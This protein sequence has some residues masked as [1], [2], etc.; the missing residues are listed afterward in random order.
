MLALLHHPDQLAALRDNPTLAG[1]AV[2]E[3]LR[4]DPPFQ[5][6]RRVAVADLDIGGYYI[7][8]GRFLIVWLATANRDPARFRDPD[9]FDIHRTDTGHLA[10]GTGIHARLGGP[11]ARL[12]AEIAFAT[13][14]RR[15]VNPR[16]DI[17]PPPYR[18]D[19]YRSLRSLPTTAVITWPC[20]TQPPGTGSGC[21]A[22]CARCAG[23][24]PTPY[25]STS[26][27]TCWTSPAGPAAPAT[28]S[29]ENWSWC[30][31]GTLRNLATVDGPPGPRHLADAPLA[32]LLV[33]TGAATEFEPAARLPSWLGL[34][35]RT[36]RPFVQ[37]RRAGRCACRRPARRRC[38]R[39]GS[40]PAAPTRRP[41]G[42]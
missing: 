34:A 27:T 11:L 19:V 25:P 32:I 40:G 22:I 9:R 7:A 13:L 18:T 31:S 29:P 23:S 20:R 15:L 8:A 37:L 30:N 17:D 12:Q 6:T 21:C 26:S 14:A 1:N 3:A 38:R 39:P 16:L 42:R 4:Y 2:D 41:A 35:D 33:L 36:D 10:F 5:F 24:A 28:A